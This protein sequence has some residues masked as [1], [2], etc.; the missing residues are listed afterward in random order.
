MFGNIKYYIKKMFP[1]IIYMASVTDVES[2][3]FMRFLSCVVITRAVFLFGLWLLV[4]GG[5]LL[6]VGVFIVGSGLLTLRG[7]VVSFASTMLALV[8][9]FGG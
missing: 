4:V 7:R 2:N 6:V 9:E 5:G 1:N 3:V 8:A